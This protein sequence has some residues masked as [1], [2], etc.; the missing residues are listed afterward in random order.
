MV[1]CYDNATRRLLLQLAER[2]FFT[3]FARPSVDKC[4]ILTPA[5]RRKREIFLQ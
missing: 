1:R 5:P 4:T 2:T 3:F